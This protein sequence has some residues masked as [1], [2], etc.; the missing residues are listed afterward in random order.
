MAGDCLTSS[1]IQ[2]SR[3]VTGVSGKPSCQLRKAGFQSLPFAVSKK[4]GSP[5]FSAFFSTLAKMGKGSQWPFLGKSSNFHNGFGTLFTP[6]K[7]VNPA[8]AKGRL[9]E[10]LE[11]SAL[12]LIVRVVSPRAL[13]AIKCSQ[14]ISFGKLPRGFPSPRPGGRVESED[15]FAL[16][17][18]KS[19]GTFLSRRVMERSPSC[20][21]GPWCKP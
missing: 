17:P 2:T 9:T 14:S 1:E 20:Y 16:C 4:N 3:K 18:C 11:L 8:V 12:L 19:H 7:E 6:F 10:L 21:L 5:N 13:E 15:P